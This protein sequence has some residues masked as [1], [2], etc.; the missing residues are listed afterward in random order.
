MLFGIFPW[1]R[2]NACGG[3]VRHPRVKAANPE[4]LYANFEL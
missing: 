4:E 2:F 3:E 1:V